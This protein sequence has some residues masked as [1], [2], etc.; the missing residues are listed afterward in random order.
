[1]KK[2][3]GTYKANRVNVQ[4]IKSIIKIELVTLYFYELTVA[5]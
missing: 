4:K 2:S 3:G 5:T 1:M